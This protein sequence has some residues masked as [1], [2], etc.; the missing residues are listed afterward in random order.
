MR[1]KAILVVA[2]FLVLAAFAGEAHSRDAWTTLTVIEETAKGTVTVVDLGA[3]GDSPGDITVWHEPVVDRA[4]KALG[5]SN[6]FCI[7]TIAGQF[8]ECQ[9]TLTLHDGTITLAST[10]AAK[11]TSPATI[12]GGTGAYAGVT[13][14]AASTLNADGSYTIVLKLRTRT[15]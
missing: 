7:R 2:G 5:T 11:G 15:R 4:K 14:E 3:K 6:G 12:T 9:W 10:E 13:G 1:E 8:S